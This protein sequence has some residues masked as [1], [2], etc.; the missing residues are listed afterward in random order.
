MAGQK[1]I[2]AAELAQRILSG[3]RNF[4]ETRLIG[5]PNLAALEN[6]VELLS[7]LRA[8]D[9]RNVP[10]IAEGSDWQGLLAPGLFFQAAKLS[11]ANL[12][13][14]NLQRADLRRAELVGARLVGADLSGATLVVARLMK[15]NLLG[16][17]LRGADLYEANPAEANL[18]DANAAG[19]RLLRIVL[20]GADLAGATLTGADLYRADLRGVLGL[21]EAHDLATARFH[22][23]IVT[24]F[25]QAVIVAAL[26]DGPLF[27]LRAE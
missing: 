24:D 2:T 22:Q 21:Q 14:A 9:L 7:Y 6:Y 13:Q 16:A 11:G 10:V 23:T 3:E 17:S 1:S 18:R 20:R 12:S 5:D 27:E 25:E 15:A 8:Q 26:R 19:A 4:T